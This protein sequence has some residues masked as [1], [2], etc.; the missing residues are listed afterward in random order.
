MATNISTMMSSLFPLNGSE[1]D[2]L[3][4]RKDSALPATSHVLVLVPTD[5]SFPNK[6][7]YRELQMV[8][9]LMLSF[10]LHW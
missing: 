4:S 9:S 2:I 1:G 10:L 8:T 6:L 3:A 7:F 5:D